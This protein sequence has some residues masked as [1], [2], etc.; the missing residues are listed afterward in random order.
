M[1]RVPGAAAGSSNVKP[2]ALARPGALSA[3]MYSR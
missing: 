2:G 3:N 1:R